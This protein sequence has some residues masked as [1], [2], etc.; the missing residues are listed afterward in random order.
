MQKIVVVLCLLVCI[1]QQSCGFISTRL[2]ARKSSS[3]NMA[4]KDMM[5]KLTPTSQNV[6]IEFLPSEKTI[7]AKVGEPLGVV[8]E[9]AGVPIKYSCKKGECGTCEVNV[10]GKWIKTCQTTIPNTKGET[11]KVTV[12]EVKVVPKKGAEFFSPKSF[13]EGVVNNGLGVVG[14]VNACANADEAYKV[15]MAREADIARRVEEEKKRKQA[16]Q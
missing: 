4:F 14:F 3:L 1:L 9:R 5:K 12:R 15:R 11:L 8:A 7:V 13:V 2:H 16:M 10:N 6:P